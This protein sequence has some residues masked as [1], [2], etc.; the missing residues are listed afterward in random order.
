ML[1]FQLQK[2]TKSRQ[3]Q[4]ES[5]VKVS[6]GQKSVKLSQLLYVP[7]LEHTLVSVS[8]LCDDENN[9]EFTNRKCLVEK[10]CDFS[11]GKRLG[12]MYSNKL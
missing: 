4:G 12:R 6:A 2:T 10:N 5:T 7:E 3:T 11:D 8:S 9:V 1:G